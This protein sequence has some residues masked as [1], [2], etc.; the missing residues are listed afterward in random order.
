MK[1]GL[2]QGSALSL[3][4]FII[5][6]DMLA[7]EARTK[8]QWAMLFADDLM[9]VSETLDEV[10]EELERWRAVI[11]NK[12]LIISRS[13][14]VYL[15]PSHQQAGKLKGEPLPSVNSFKYLGSVIDGSGGCGKH[16]D[17]RIKVAWSRWGGGDLFGVIYDKKV[18]MKLKSKLYK[19]VVRPAMVYASECWALRFIIIMAGMS[20]FFYL[21]GYLI[22]ERHRWPVITA[23]PRGQCSK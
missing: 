3:L 2:H 12:G 5:I 8:P 14:T 18:H 20:G 1:V 10:E 15:V 23:S 16:V 22:E 19:T 6:M 9:L 17:G 13:K 4:L 7:E 21:A 11:E